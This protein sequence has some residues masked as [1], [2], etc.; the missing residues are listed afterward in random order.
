MVGADNAASSPTVEQSLQL[1]IGDC[2]SPKDSHYRGWAK[3]QDDQ[4]DTEWGDRDD[5]FL[6]RYESSL[7]ALESIDG[8]KD[9]PQ[10]YSFHKLP[11]HRRIEPRS[12]ALIAS[13]F[14]HLEGFLWRLKDDE[15]RDRGLRQRTRYGT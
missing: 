12:L 1:C 14:P 11:S 7:L 10:V 6:H 15:K 5:L 3:Y 8:I 2:Y 4:L 13:K 9:V